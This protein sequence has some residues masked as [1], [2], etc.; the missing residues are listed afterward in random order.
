MF[1]TAVRNLKLDGS[2]P[3][4]LT[5]YGGYGASLPPDYDPDIPMWL[6]LG[7][8]YAVANIRGGG[9]YG[10]SWHRTGML[11]PNRTCSTIFWRRRS[12]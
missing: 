7:G 2:H 10:E 1:V 9:E 8:V 6:T 11:E 3:T 5:A 4:L 12:F